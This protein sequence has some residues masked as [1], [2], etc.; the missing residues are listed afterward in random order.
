M[1][2]EN[3]RLFQVQTA[4]LSRLVNAT[5]FRHGDGRKTYTVTVISE[6]GHNTIPVQTREDALICADNYI[7]QFARELAVAYHVKL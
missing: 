7:Q 4:G 3:L 1:M 2:T 6:H 5:E